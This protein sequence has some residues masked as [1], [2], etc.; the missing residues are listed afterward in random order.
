MGCVSVLTFPSI[1]I[2]LILILVILVIDF[3]VLSLLFDVDVVAAVAFEDIVGRVQ[4]GDGDFG[5]R[6]LERNRTGLVAHR[7]LLDFALR[8]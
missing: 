1:D 2:G 5:G 6:T 8:R 7:E 3:F 4:L